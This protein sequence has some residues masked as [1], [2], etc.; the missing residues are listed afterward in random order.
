[1]GIQVGQ[2][3]SGIRRGKIVP[4][5]QDHLKEIRRRNGCYIC[6][7]SESQTV[8]KAKKLSLPEAIVACQLCKG[9][10][11]RLTTNTPADYGAPSRSFRQTAPGHQSNARPW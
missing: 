8:A 2:R 7:G 9:E 3:S 1:M 6:S 5:L 11:N 10:Q 4:G